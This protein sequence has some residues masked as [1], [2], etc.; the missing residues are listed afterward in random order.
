MD[1]RP[2]PGR[3]SRKEGGDVEDANA[4]L[5]LPPIEG[6][7]HFSVKVVHRR[8]VTAEFNSDARIRVIVVLRNL[9]GEN[10]VA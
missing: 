2:N 5:N 4:R 6:F 3:T 10:L 7:L 9:T 8:G 1:W